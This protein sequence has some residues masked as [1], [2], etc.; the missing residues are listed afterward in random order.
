MTPIKEWIDNKIKDKDIDYFE[1]DTFSNIVEIGRGGFGKVSK[2]YL[3]SMGIEVAIK[4][5]IYENSEIEENNIDKL[6]EIV[7]EVG[8]TFFFYI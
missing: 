2:A 8:I 5:S 3:N 4:S 7:K 6:N 1:Y